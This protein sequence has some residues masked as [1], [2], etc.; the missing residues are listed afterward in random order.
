[1]RRRSIVALLATLMVM[2]MTL[3]ASAAFAGEVT[4]SGRGGPDGDGAPGATESAN[5]ICAFSG[6]N[7]D[8]TDSRPFEDGRVQ[9]FGDIIQELVDEPGDGHGA[10]ALVEMIRYEGPGMA[11]NPNRGAEH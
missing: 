7:D 4:G 10:S 9:S 1:M 6:L 8:P 2:A 5:S 3:G 11:C